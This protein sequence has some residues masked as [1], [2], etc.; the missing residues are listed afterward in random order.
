MADG[1]W[2]GCGKLGNLE[3]I[4][5]DEDYAGTRVESRPIRTEGVSAINQLR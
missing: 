5:D 2:C 3:I 1:R 4:D